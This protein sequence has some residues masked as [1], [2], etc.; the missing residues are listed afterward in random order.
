ML[1]TISNDKDYPNNKNS[2]FVC[3]LD[4]P[5]CFTSPHEVALTELY[6]KYDYTKDFGT[7]KLVADSSIILQKELNSE[8]FIKHN[9]FTKITEHNL[10]TKH[11]QEIHAR[12]ET[13]FYAVRNESVYEEVKQ[14]DVL[15]KLISHFYKECTDSFME[16]CEL[17][18]VVT[19]TQFIGTTSRFSQRIKEHVSRSSLETLANTQD[20]KLIEL[21]SHPTQKSIQN[22]TLELNLYD[23]KPL[24][25]Q[26][27]LRYSNLFYIGPLKNKLT[28]KDPDQKIYYTGLHLAIS[29]NHEITLLNKSVKEILYIYTDIVDDS[30]LF[31][32]S[33]AILRSI[34]PQ[35]IINELEG[36]IFERPN[37][38]RLRRN[39]ISKLRI[40]IRDQHNNLIDFKENS[41]IIKLEF[42]RIRR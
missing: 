17:S 42:R 36:H 14:L 19:L 34:R 26:I 18:N 1:I 6:F 12:I 15:S 21:Y 37:F 2:D 23:S 27:F 10:L 35:G 38:I 3:V 32:G 28:L 40:T 33:A 4:E 13:A 11:A 16:L 9:K 30:K 39:Y 22:F 25:E 8:E 41:V 5:L 24:L 29:N 20:K 31:N 7:I